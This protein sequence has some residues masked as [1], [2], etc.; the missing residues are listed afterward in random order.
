MIEINE[1]VWELVYTLI[2]N[3]YYW[4][5]NMGIQITVFLLR[6]KYFKYIKFKTTENFKLISL[7]ASYCHHSNK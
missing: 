6:I 5:K 1:I 4:K 2:Q 7:F 3:G